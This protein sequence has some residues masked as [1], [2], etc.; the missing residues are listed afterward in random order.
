VQV[1]RVWN[2]TRALVRHGDRAASCFRQRAISGLQASSSVPL[3]RASAGEVGVCSPRVAV[4]V[5]VD[6]HTRVTHVLRSIGD[7]RHP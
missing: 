2:S 4:G 6:E 3:L 7:T 1:P 5:A